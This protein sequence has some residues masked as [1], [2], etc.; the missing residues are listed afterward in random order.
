VEQGKPP[1][2]P[3]RVAITA[4]GLRTSTGRRL[5]ISAGMVAQVDLE[6]ERRSVLRY[7][8]TPVARLRERA[9][10]EPN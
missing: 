1:L 3:V 6:G 8:L 10:R 7:L 4:P 5:D 2:F 9:F